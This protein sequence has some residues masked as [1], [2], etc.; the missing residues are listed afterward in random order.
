M[1]Y[2]RAPCFHLRGISVLTERCDSAPRGSLVILVFYDQPERAVRVL[3]SMKQLRLSGY[4]DGMNAHGS[5]H[6]LVM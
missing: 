2:Y 4:Q 6:Y 3:A 1:S 5:F